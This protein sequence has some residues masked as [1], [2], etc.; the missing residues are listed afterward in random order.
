MK[1]KPISSLYSLALALSLALLSFCTPSLRA[2]SI[3]VNFGGFSSGQLAST[4]LAGVP[5]F[6]QTH[7]VNVTSAPSSLVL[8]DS[9]GATT[10]ARLSGGN[11]VSFSTQT[12]TFAGPDEALNL[13]YAGG[14]G[15]S[16][17]F[18]LTNIP[19]ATYSLVV[20]DLGLS[21]NSIQSV[22]ALSTVTTTFY[23]SSPNP[24][25]AGYIDGNSSTP[26]TYTQGTG[27]TQATATTN[28]DYVVFPALTGTNLTFVMSGYSG[29]TLVRGFQIVNAVP[30]PSTWVLG[31]G[32]IAMFGVAFYRRRA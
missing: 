28:A 14:F 1:T 21:T 5:S 3:G 31:M 6:A 18:T 22:T 25:G 9:N 7:W 26:F 16:F 19:Y 2:E 27:T 4:D 20:Y 24:T 17:S 8:G 11:G 15:G 29:S 32:G 10:T 13:S 23:T 12:Q 30:E